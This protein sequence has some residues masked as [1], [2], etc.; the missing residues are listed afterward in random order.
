MTQGNEAVL[1]LVE[2]PGMHCLELLLPNNRVCLRKL[3][4]GGTAVCDCLCVCTCVCVCICVCVSA[5]CVCVCVSA[6]CVCTCARV[7]VSL[8]R[9]H[10]L[11]RFSFSFIWSLI[12]LS[13]SDLAV[14]RY[15]VFLYF[16][17]RK[18]KKPE[19]FQES[20]RFVFVL[21]RMVLVLWRQGFA[22]WE[23]FAFGL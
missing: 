22:P 6:W 15:L 18:K 11:I 3:R 16:Q 19:K 7:C 12:F 9:L 20:L 13:W 17:P 10:F 4:K 14:G 5:W 23:S 2:L 21:C 8:T 1:S